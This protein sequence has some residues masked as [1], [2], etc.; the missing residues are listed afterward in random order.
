MHFVSP[1]VQAW[2]HLFSV[3]LSVICGLNTQSDVSFSVGLIS[4]HFSC[5][6]SHFGVEQCHL[7]VP[8][9]YRQISSWLVCWLRMLTDSRF[10][11]C[12]LSACGLNRYAGNE[13][14]WQR[15]TSSTESILHTW[16]ICYGCMTPWV[17]SLDPVQLYNLQCMTNS[18]IN[19]TVDKCSY[20]DLSL[21]VASTTLSPCHLCTTYITNLPLLSLA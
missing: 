13:H 21:I 6:V 18:S 15:C 16:M 2:F 9:R 14:G 1:P 10:W 17:M 11:H 5:S 7:S 19:W 8:F 20:H 3:A 4:P 12:I